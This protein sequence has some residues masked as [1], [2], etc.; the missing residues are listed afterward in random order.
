MVKKF[1]KEMPKDERPIN[2][3]VLVASLIVAAAIAVM[4]YSCGANFTV[5]LAIALVIVL[6][7]CGYRFSLLWVLF[8]N[9]L[10]G[11]PRRS[12][13]DYIATGLTGC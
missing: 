10:N 4:A 1:F 13:S 9:N 8:K 6:L 11:D 12:T 5:S 7:V 3:F 2:A